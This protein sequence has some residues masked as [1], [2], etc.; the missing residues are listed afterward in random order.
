MNYPYAGR[1][2]F[3]E[4]E[5]YAYAKCDSVD[6]LDEWQKSR[7]AAK[8]AFV[9]RV[10]ERSEAEGTIRVDVPPGAVALHSLL[11]E[12]AGS[13]GGRIRGRD[14]AGVLEPFIV[15]FEVFG[16]LFAWYRNDGR[17][18]P[19]S[20]TA[21]LATYVLF[22]Q[23]LCEI[24]ET[25]GSLKHLSILLKLCDALASQS[26]DRFEPTDASALADILAR[27]ASLVHAVAER[28]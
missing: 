6:Y 10:N 27:E 11:Q 16:R 3:A 1:D 12:D 21:D 19:E 24:A 28:N 4:P 14:A 23:R 25:S 8:L 18:H 17:R 22:A 5:S 9:R 26:A 2:L 15:K 13:N 20:P 7:S